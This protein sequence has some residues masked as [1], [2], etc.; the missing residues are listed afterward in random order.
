MA[1]EIRSPF[2]RREE[3]EGLPEAVAGN[4]ADAVL[5][6]VGEVF[7]AI[8]ARVSVIERALESVIEDVEIIMGVAEQAPE[9]APDQGLDAEPNDG[10][11]ADG[12]EYAGDDTSASNGE[13]HDETPEEEA[14]RLR[15]EAIA[16]FERENES[17][18]AEAAPDF[19]DV[20]DVP[21]EGRD[22]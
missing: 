18:A 17:E 2:V 9:I 14:A 6:Q 10:Y 5:E 8:E 13:D 1:R 20:A 11:G 12:S 22:V 19:N 15:R 4:V 21:L 16:A 7:A 3:L